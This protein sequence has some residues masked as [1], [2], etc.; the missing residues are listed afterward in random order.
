MFLDHWPSEPL[1]HLLVL[2][3][4]AVGGFWLALGLTRKR[5]QA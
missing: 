5:F 3:V 4:Y 2:G 1:R